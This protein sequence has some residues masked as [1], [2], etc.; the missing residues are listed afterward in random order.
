MTEEPGAHTIGTMPPANRQSLLQSIEYLQSNATLV[1][2]FLLLIAAL[3]VFVAAPVLFFDAVK[4]PFIGAFVEHTLMI[5]GSRPITSGA[6]SDAL[7]L[8]SGYQVQ[9]VDGQQ[10]GSVAEMRGV[11]NQHQ[12][13]QLIYLDIAHP[14]EGSRSVSVE[15]SRLSVLDQLGYFVAP[16]LTGL[17]YLLS[18]LYVFVI[19]RNDPAGRAFSIFSGATAISLATLFD[20]YTTNNLTLLWAGAL[21]LAGGG[22]VNLALLFPESVR[23]VAR[24]PLLG[25]SGYLLSLI[26]ATASFI[27]IYNFNAPAAYVWVWR[28]TYLY[29]AAGVVLF[30]GLSIER[31]RHASSPVVREQARLIFWG[32]IAAFLPPGVWLLI[33][34][35]WPAVILTPVLLI[36]L[37]IFPIFVGY[38][39]IRY[40]LLRTD[41]LISRTVMY[42][43]LAAL[44]M[45]GYGLLV[46]G[47]TLV[48][49][50]W[51]K[52]TNPLVIGAIVFALALAMNPIRNRL[53]EMIDRYFF[54]GQIVF[55]EL[56]QAL[57]RELTQV[58]ELSEMVRL[59]R[60]YVEQAFSP[61]FLHI[62]VYDPL[63]GHYVATQDMNDRMTTD[64]RF[65]ASSP[66]V[67]MLSSQRESLFLADINALPDALQPEQARIMLLS[68]SLFIP[69]LG[70]SQ[71]IGWVALGNRRSGEPYTNRDLAFLESLSDQ[72]ALAVERAQV[73]EDLERRVREMNVLTRVA[74]GVSFTVAFD[75]ILEMISAQTNQVLPA[76][77]LKVTLIDPETGVMSNAFYLENDER[78]TDLEHRPLHMGQ[79]LEAE[80]ISAQRAIVT[81]DYERE[82]RSRG[83][84]PT[85]QGLYAWMGVP[86]NAGA[87]TIGALSVASRDPVDT[88]TEEQRNLLQAIADQASGA[89]V[90]ARSLDESESRA[91][92]LAKLNE[93]GVGLTSTLDIKP[94]LEQ[95]L[96]SAVDILSCEAGTLFLMDNQTDE[97]IFEV[98]HGPVAEALVG[99]RLAPGTG[100]AGQAVTTGRPVIANDAKRRM[101]WSETSDENTGFNTQDLLVVPMRIQDRVIGV[102]EV[103]NKTNGAPFTSADQELL[104]AF[105]SQATIAI[106]NARLYTMTDQALAA[107]VEELSVMQ[108]IDRE[109][110]ASLDIERAM[111]ITLDWAMRQ[112]HAEAGLV[113]AVLADRL[114]VMVAQGYQR[115]LDLFPLEEDG[116]HHS[117][118]LN[119]PALQAAI[120]TGQP[121]CTQVGAGNGTGA[122]ILQQGRLQTVIPIRRETTTMGVM[123]LESTHSEDLPEDMLSF[124]MR[125]S[126]HAAIAIANAELYEEVKE[127]NLAKSR[128][129]SFVAHELKNPMASIKGYTELV[130]Q[131]MAGPVNEMQSSFLGTVRSN[132]DRMNTIVTDLSDLTK[133]QVGN[134]RLEYKAVRVTDALNEVMRSIER[135]VEEKKQ[136]STVS[137]P[138]NLPI[139][140]ADPVRLSQILTNLVSNAHK[141]TPEEG[142]FDVG[143]EVYIPQEG[144]MAGAK[145]V[146]LWVKDQGIG[147]SEEDQKKIFTQYFRTDNAKEMASGTGLGL[148]ITRSLIEMMGGRIWFDSVI[149]QGTTFH[150]TLPVAEVMEQG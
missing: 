40:R 118:P 8:L 89:I 75:D 44:A 132:V 112:S 72:A 9:A 43:L 5:S 102:I 93:I 2:V 33:T 108:R 19:R 71:L 18:A 105:T 142:S 26:L 95:I 39:I 74:Q 117:L 115:E 58:M 83:L 126:D 144:A 32:G 16:Y 113:G 53:Q 65:P 121:N 143:A 59:L 57:S 66:L 12:P 84:L 150:F 135:Q 130:A 131:G 56:Q 129:V 20:L 125:L 92:Q 24:N 47:L 127:A 1:L 106:E 137:L 140:W 87:L 38:A 97:L 41:F 69:L 61:Q 145:F 35:L 49:G 73:V 139:V 146:H 54:R 13:G 149:N 23:N 110:N 10:V 67:R 94:L 55:R 68:A 14:Q 3:V 45:A 119:L 120:E 148:S 29:L 124:L 96:E 114:R 52:P 116:V 34:L 30:L 141:Y 15:L 85:T 50:D 82:C 17:I 37:A 7:H 42:G 51:F 36:S 80:V 25:W 77:D 100:L 122:G 46:S 21:A 79:G 60:R 98:V 111:R 48:F 128:F 134:M 31:W 27:T 147:I 28:V 107:R 86:L 78:L 123:V 138:D 81:D 133:I 62:F 101:E 70:R 90:K 4:T 99:Q 6:S 76:R 22:L 103:I 91:R 88:Y 11:L 64:V 136:Q 104:L 63:S 109:L